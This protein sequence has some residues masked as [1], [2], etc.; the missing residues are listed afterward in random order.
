M[1]CEK[2]FVLSI[3]IIRC[4]QWSLYD[5]CFCLEI[6]PLRKFSILENDLVHLYVS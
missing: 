5:F 6:T 3:N 4:N 2:K 1:T